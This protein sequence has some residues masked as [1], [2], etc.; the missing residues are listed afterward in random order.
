MFF[1]FNHIFPRFFSPAFAPKKKHQK[2]QSVHPSS[3]WLEAMFFELSKYGSA[4]L[5][6]CRGT[7][8]SLK[9][10]GFLGNIYTGNPMVSLP[11]NIW[12]NQRAF[13]VS[14][15]A[16]TKPL[17]ITFWISGGPPVVRGEN[18]CFNIIG[19]VR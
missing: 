13:L 1:C 16:V 14:S 9:D 6:P 4:N 17:N 12:M 18:H 19:L 5:D 2:K 7:V 8:T 11:L 3:K 15:L 10:Y